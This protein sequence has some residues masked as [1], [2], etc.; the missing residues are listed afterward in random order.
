[1]KLV[2]AE[3]PSV[4]AELAR[5]LGAKQKRNGYF[6]GNNYVVTWSL[7]HLMTLKMPE[8]YHPEWAEWTFDTLPL[9]PKHLETTPLK[10]TRKQLAVVKTLAKRGDIT[11]AIIATDAGREGELVA[12]Y[13][14]NYLNFNKPLKRLWISSQTDKAIRDGFQHLAPAKQYDN[15]YQAALARAEADWLIGLNVSRALTI[16]YDDS[17]SAG[18]VQTPTLAFVAD[19]EQKRNQFKPESFAV[20]SVQTS[21]GKATL[22]QQF[23]ADKAKTIAAGLNQ[24]PLTVTAVK[25]KHQREQA[26]LPFDL[27][28]LQQVANQKFGYSPKQT[29]NYLQNLYE[30]EKAVTYPRTDSRYLTTDL[31]A[32]MGDRLQAIRRYHDDAIKGA[33]L[34]KYVYNDAKV[35]DHYGLIP[36][37]QAVDPAKLDRDELNIYRL[38]VGRFVDL[39]KPAYEAEQLTYTLKAGDYALTLK[40]VSVIEPGFKAVE[41]N[42]A[43]KLSVGA[44]IS[45]HA[46][47]EMKQTQ[48]PALLNEASLLG[49]MEHFGLGTPATR[50]DIIDKLQ[51][52]G[53]MAK[54][55][56]DL[57]VTA[58]GKQLLKLVNPRLV[59]PELTAKWEA[60]LKAIEA[61]KL[62]R[63]TF[64]DEIKTETK[65]LV[66]EVKQSQAKYEDHSLTGKICPDCG[67]NLR[68]KQTKQGVLLVC[69]NCGYKRYRDPKV[70]NHRCSQCHKKMVILT[71]AKGDYFKCLNCGNTEAMTQTKGNKRMNKRE[72]QRL[73]KKY[74]QDE[75]PE[76]SPLA[77]ALKAAMKQD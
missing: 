61:G 37:E 29:L 18:R 33:T 72:E 11:E 27:N 53:S 48:P 70:T 66:L 34:P 67:Q 41:K 43:A 46:S 10:Q 26:P 19:Q 45:G 65:T 71:G 5:V 17:L 51:N 8:Q 23:S 69:N 16:K 12:R 77:A 14:F 35:G 62:S 74:S 4:G 56:R 15:L 54:Q 7:G 22:S 59:S 52:S 20:V 6:E 28:E 36:T 40:T 75:A 13:I 21:L 3:K 31:Q 44:T 64:I 68:E 30:R 73:L 25:A 38:I 39:F 47:V 24:Q 42:Q 32:T 49:K 1:V 55:G 57:T 76:E 60:S 9:I 63:T 58:K 2:L 50:A